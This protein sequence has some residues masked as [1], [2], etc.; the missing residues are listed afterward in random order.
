MVGSD[1]PGTPPAGATGP[2]LDDP[3][4]LLDA[5][6]DV[7][8]RLI[9]GGVPRPAMTQLQKLLRENIGDYPWQQVTQRILAEPVDY[10][11]LVQ[12][13]LGAHRDWVW[14]G[15]REKP[16]PSLAHRGKGLLA[17][18][19]AQAIF[20][21]IWAIVVVIALL[22]IK[23]GFPNFDIYAALDWLYDT[24]PSLKPK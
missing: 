21:A 6:R 7:S 16:A 10:Q 24:F 14:R 5:I 8:L 13:A 3:Q 20:L 1:A 4:Q 11:K 2:D 9:A 17:K 19:C 15:G 18:I 22:A 23:H 12:Q